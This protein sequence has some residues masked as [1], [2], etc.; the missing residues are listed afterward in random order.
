MSKQAKQPVVNVGPDHPAWCGIDDDDWNRATLQNWLGS[1]RGRTVVLD[2]PRDAR[3]GLLAEM[4]KALLAAGAIVE[5]TFKGSLPL[6]DMLAAGESVPVRVAPEKARGTA[7][8]RETVRKLAEG[9][10]TARE[11]G[12]LRRRRAR[13]RRRGEDRLWEYKTLVQQTMEH[14]QKMTELA[15]GALRR[16]TELIGEDNK[17]LSEQNAALMD[18]N[19]ELMRRLSERDG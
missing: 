9:P 16:V 19:V 13:L 10:N 5:Y 14:H 12:I 18:R 8:W 2:P 11:R 6:P 3:S 15:N 7:A 4:A 1:V 17:R